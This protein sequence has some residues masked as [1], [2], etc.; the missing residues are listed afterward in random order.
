MTFSLTGEAVP[1]PSSI[2]MMSIGGMAVCGIC[3]YRR[4]RRAA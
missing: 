2:M 4:R 3:V 1:E